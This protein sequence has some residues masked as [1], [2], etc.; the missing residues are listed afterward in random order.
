MADL[1]FFND[2]DHGDA[3]SVEPAA[4]RV[5]YEVLCRRHHRR[6]LTAGRAQAASLSPDVLPL[7]GTP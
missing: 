7:D 2:P 1:V 4:A 6:R 5:H 3:R